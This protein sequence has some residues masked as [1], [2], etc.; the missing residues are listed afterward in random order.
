MQ[1]TTARIAATAA[2]TG[3][4]VFGGYGLASAQEEDPT[5]TT[6]Q[7]DS[8]ATT[9][10]E[11]TDESTAPSDNGTAED[12]SGEDCPHD[13]QSDSDSGTSEGSTED[14]TTGS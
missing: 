7:E 14:A 5:T 8:S 2:I 6:V 9:T 1:R 10:E 4:L 3:A 11:S 13:R 12:R